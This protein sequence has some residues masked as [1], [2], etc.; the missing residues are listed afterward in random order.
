MK[1]RMQH[2]S[3]IE[4]AKYGDAFREE[5]ENT[6][7]KSIIEH[8]EECN[9]CKKNVLEILYS[10][11][12]TAKRRITNYTKY[13][14]YAAAIVIIVLP[15]YYIT[16]F[17]NQNK[18]KKISKSSKILAEKKQAANS[19]IAEV[20]NNDKLYS[21]IPECE[22]ICG[23]N[24]RSNSVDVSSPQNSFVSDGK[25]TFS[26][27]FYTAAERVLNIYNNKDKLI[28]SI[29]IKELKFNQSLSFSEGLYYWKIE[30]ESEM[31]YLGKFVIKK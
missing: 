2:L 17:L 1:N 31:E 11:E 22:A 14:K 5:R 27:K 29:E 16:N 19:L 21:V 15:L 13:I 20:Q 24:F 7:D 4:I 30:T 28:K 18:E 9:I 6:V 3:E 23:D 8:L 25:I 10:V 12:E 26:I